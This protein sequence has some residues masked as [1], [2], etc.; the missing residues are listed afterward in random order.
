MHENNFIT[1]SIRRSSSL[2]RYS[3]RLRKDTNLHNDV[4]DFLFRR[5]PSISRLV[6]KLLS[7][8]FILARYTDPTY[9]I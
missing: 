2:L 8:E 9:P 5:Q 1:N 3:V 4:D 6:D 7:N